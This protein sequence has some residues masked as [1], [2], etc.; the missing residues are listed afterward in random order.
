MSDF[1]IIFVHGYTA[2]HLAD[3]YPDISKE[4]DALGVDYVV[5]DLPGGTRPH[6]KDWLEII[7]REVKS[8]GKPVVLVGHSL[9]SRAVLLYLDQYKAPAKAVFLIAAF[10][11]WTENAKRRD[12]EA[13]PDFFEHQLDIEAIKQLCGRFVVIHSRDDDSIDYKQGQKIAKDLDAKLVTAEGRGHL[14]QPDNAA[15]VLDQLRSELGF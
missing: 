14:F 7:D 11:N 4:L 5:P 8:A 6:S 12:G 13:Y 1:K 15:F 9:G 10:A 2:S 3:W